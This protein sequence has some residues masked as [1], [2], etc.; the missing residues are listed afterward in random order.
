MKVKFTIQCGYFPQIHHH[1]NIKNLLSP[2][3]PKFVQG[4]KSAILAIFQK[5]KCDQNKIFHHIART[6][7]RHFDS[8]NDWSESSFFTRTNNFLVR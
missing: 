6:N 5:V 4:F 7:P 2:R 8:M 1:L 3:K